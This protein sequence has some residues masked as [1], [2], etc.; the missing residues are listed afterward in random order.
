MR[1]TGVG[2]LRQ[3]KE[4]FAEL[5]GKKDGAARGLGGSM[6]LYKR[7]NNFFGGIGIVGEQARLL[8]MPHAVMLCRTRFTEPPFSMHSLD[9]SGICLAALVSL[10]S[11]LTKLIS[12]SFRA[13]N[14]ILSRP[15][16]PFHVQGSFLTLLKLLR[17]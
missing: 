8:F 13:T 15:P 2:R 1:Q 7:K 10:A 14:L 12:P 5:L 6:H 3:P 11:R 16:L 17:F 9:G 4:V